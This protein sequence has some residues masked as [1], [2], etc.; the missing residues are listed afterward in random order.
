MSIV[1]EYRKLKPELE[2]GW[3]WDDSDELNLKVTKLITDEIDFGTHTTTEKQKKSFH[4]KIAQKIGEEVI[5]NEILAGVMVEDGTFQSA[6]EYFTELG[7]EI[8]EKK[9]YKMKL[10]CPYCDEY[11]EISR[12]VVVG[13]DFYSSP[14]YLCLGKNKD[15]EE[16]KDNC[17]QFKKYSIEIQTKTDK[18][19][20]MNDIREYIKTPNRF[21][22]CDI[23]SLGGTIKASQLYAEDG[24]MTFFVGNSGVTIS[25]D[26]NEENTFYLYENGFFDEDSNENIPNLINKG[27]VSCGLWWVMGADQSD[28]NMAE[29]MKDEYDKPTIIDV[30]PNSTY[31][32][33]YD[34]TEE[35]LEKDQN[36]VSKGFKFYKK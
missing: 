20:I 16:P 6:E 2:S 23:N 26:A 10:R 8:L 3:N 22:E 7:N 18:F 35:R 13:K 34:M 15:G 9:L 29:V 1:S 33:E 27:S 30:I 25:Q 24:I 4:R 28:L 14:R 5:F 36:Y 17:F 32:L 21:S 19:V 12:K 31:I 11:F